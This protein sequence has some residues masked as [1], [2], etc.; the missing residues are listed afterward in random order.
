MLESQISLILI[1]LSI[2]TSLFVYVG[3]KV[4]DYMNWKREL[5]GLRGS[6]SV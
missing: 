2:N 6:K 4:V 5:Q 3:M 1:L